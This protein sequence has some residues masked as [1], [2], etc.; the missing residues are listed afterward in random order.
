MR[1]AQVSPGQ[2]RSRARY[3]AIL[4]KLPKDMREDEPDYNKASKLWDP[5]QPFIPYGRSPGYGKAGY[6]RRPVSPLGN[7]LGIPGIPGIPWAALEP[8]S[9]ATY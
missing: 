5:T 9:C 1:A 7:P 6:G 4:T 8:R 3:P 2:D